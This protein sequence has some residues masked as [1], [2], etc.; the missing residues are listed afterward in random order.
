MQDFRLLKGFKFK[1]TST[2]TLNQITIFYHA[3]DGVR[4]FTTFWVVGFHPTPQRGSFCGTMSSFVDEYVLGPRRYLG[5]LEIH[6][7]DG[8]V[9]RFDNPMPVF[10]DNEIITIQMIPH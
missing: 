7:S 4:A 9:Y 5:I 6:T 10:G 3:A 8:S 2:Q 1:P